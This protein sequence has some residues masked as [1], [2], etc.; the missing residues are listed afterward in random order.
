M[1]KSA[2]K[3]RDGCY[4]P[5][6][7]TIRPESRSL[8]FKISLTRSIKIYHVHFPVFSSESYLQLE[9]EEISHEK[10]I[11]NCTDKTE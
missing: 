2:R 9:M 4:G 5:G 3:S 7:F 8:S 6:K 11:E 1:R 10:S